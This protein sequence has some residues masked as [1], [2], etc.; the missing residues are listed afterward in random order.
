MTPLFT[1]NT[2]AG[3]LTAAKIRVRRFDILALNLEGLGDATVRL[4]RTNPQT[5]NGIPCIFGTTDTIVLDGH[6]IVDGVSGEYY[7]EQTGTADGLYASLE[8]QNSAHRS[9]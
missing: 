2:A 3:D 8:T 6:Y 9:L 7:I 1:N 4:M 5:G